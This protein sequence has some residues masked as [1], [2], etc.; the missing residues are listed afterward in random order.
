MRP[1][2]APKALA[3]PK[4]TAGG[5]TIARSPHHIPQKPH[6]TIEN[7]LFGWELLEASGPP[8]Y[9]GKGRDVFIPIAVG[10]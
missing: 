2:A 9:P 8:H 3:P 7:G 10:Q 6:H 4:M 1:K 5:F